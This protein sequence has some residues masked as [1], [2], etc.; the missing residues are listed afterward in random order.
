MVT[1]DTKR[2]TP[3]MIDP[4][5]L[6]STRHVRILLEYEEQVFLASAIHDLIKSGR[7]GDLA[8]M[9]SYFIFHRYGEHFPAR[10]VDSKLLSNLAS[11]CQRFEIGADVRVPERYTADGFSE[12]LRLPLNVGTVLAE[13]LAFLETHSSLLSKTRRTVSYFKQ[14]GK[15]ILDVTNHMR[16]RKPAA[17]SRLR[18]PRWIISIALPVAGLAAFGPIGAYLG[19][20]GS[21]IIAVFDP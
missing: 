10:I 4:S 20:A 17:F 19:A 11:R 1:A 8:K 13:E 7:T 15:L 6:T 21:S 16:D 12:S 14:R 9:V 18:G 3:Y 2:F 5:V